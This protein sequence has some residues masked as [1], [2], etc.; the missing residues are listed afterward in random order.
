MINSHPSTPSP[1]GK[2]LAGLQLIVQQP[3]WSRGPQA[4]Y[5]ISSPDYSPEVSGQ[6]PGGNCLRNPSSMT[7][8]GPTNLPHDF[9][10]L[11]EWG[12]KKCSQHLMEFLF[13][14]KFNTHY[15]SQKR[16]L[17]APNYILTNLTPGTPRQFRNRIPYSRDDSNAGGGEAQTPLSLQPPFLPST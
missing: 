16:V 13:L 5:L 10:Q 1:I 8:A 4:T 7:H 9:H 17:L 15:K 3:V 12:V 11:Q 14:I 2:A 6:I